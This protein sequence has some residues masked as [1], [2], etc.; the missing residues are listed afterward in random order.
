VINSALAEA[1]SGTD[2]ID[3]ANYYFKRASLLARTADE[4]QQLERLKAMISKPG[5]KP[6]PDMDTTK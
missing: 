1:H 5:V 4:N 2:N 6:D 3:S